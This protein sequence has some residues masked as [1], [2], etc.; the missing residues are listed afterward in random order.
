M[1]S[2]FLALLLSFQ[3]SCAALAKRYVIPTD[4]TVL[5]TYEVGPGEILD[6]NHFEALVW[7]IY[8]ADKRA[9]FS[10]WKRLGL[11]QDLILIQEA[12]ESETFMKS[13]GELEVSEAV[14]ARSWIDAKKNSIATG[15]M[16]L[17]SA[18]N[19]EKIWV[20]SPGREPFVRTPKMTLI[21]FYNFK[22]V[23]DKLMV[24]NIHALN[25]TSLNSFK[26]TLQ[27]FKE[28]IKKHDGPV[29][30]AGD[31]NTHINSRYTYMQNYFR[32]LNF[33]QVQFTPDYRFRILGRYL[34]FAFVRGLKVESAEAIDS[35]G[36]DHNPML[37]KLS[38][39]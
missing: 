13:I 10:E 20:R 37:L 29:L 23:K 36:S 17:S 16:T 39:F 9:F 32:E 2:I 6:P 38:L 18:K 1:R 4:D 27:Q 15:V 34:D 19:V 25:F 22:G 11:N 30:F 26:R 35:P 31:F 8:K 28:L 12:W 7:N 14:M 21:T 3:V 24:I 5:K 33:N